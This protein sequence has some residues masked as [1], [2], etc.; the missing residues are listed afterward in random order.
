MPT[1]IDRE[2]DLNQA[3]YRAALQLQ[4]ANAA[5][6]Q[7]SLL[8]DS[9]PSAC[10]VTIKRSLDGENWTGLQSAQ[11]FAHGSF[12]ASILSLMTDKIDCAGFDWLA[13][14]VTTAEGAALIGRLTIFANRTF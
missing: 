12:S 14:E 2:F 13:A 10:I 11:T 5:T 1:K 9:T 4:G 3:G 8:S 7:L 6:V